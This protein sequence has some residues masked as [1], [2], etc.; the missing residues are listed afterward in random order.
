MA[1]CEAVIYLGLDGGVGDAR[2]ARAREELGYEL[3][4]SFEDGPAE[5]RA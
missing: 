1:G 2:R 5:L 3:V 4:I